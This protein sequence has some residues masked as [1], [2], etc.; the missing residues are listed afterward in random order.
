MGSFGS[1]EGDGIASR[2]GGGSACI[3][4]HDF[5]IGGGSSD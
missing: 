4:G 2:N 5:A 1:I 3:D